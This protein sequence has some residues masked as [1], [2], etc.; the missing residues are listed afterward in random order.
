M[1]LGKYGRLFENFQLR[2]QSG[3]ERA[4][5]ETSFGFRRFG[6][7]HCRTKDRITI[8]E[9]LIPEIIFHKKIRELCV[10]IEIFHSF[11]HFQVEIKIKHVKT[12]LLE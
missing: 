9:I 7:N 3:F 10:V 8:L 1:Y 6:A 5:N 11:R 4:Q 2:T 12:F